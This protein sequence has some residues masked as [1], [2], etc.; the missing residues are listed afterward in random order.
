VLA[1]KG[2]GGLGC[3]KAPF[4]IPFI[5]NSTAPNVPMPNL[6]NVIDAAI[7]Q[8]IAYKGDTLDDLAKV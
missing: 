1:T 4:T 5:G 6:Q 3:K 7:E 8:D 2:N